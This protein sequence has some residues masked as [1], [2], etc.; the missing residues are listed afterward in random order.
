VC[1]LEGVERRTFNGA[2]GDT[3]IRD[4]REICKD[5]V[6]ET[7]QERFESLLQELLNALDQREQLKKPTDP[8]K[9]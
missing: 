1:I 8:C 9:V 4:W 5:V 2:S 7:S 3:K 6:Q